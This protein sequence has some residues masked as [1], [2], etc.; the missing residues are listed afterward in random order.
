MDFYSVE[1]HDNTMHTTI[2][3]ILVKEAQHAFY[4]V[5]G[6]KFYS[7]GHANKVVD[8]LVHVIGPN[9]VLNMSRIQWQRRERRSISR[10]ACASKWTSY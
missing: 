4:R 2:I 1:I 7:R 9:N 3:D 5:L 8:C 6:A 10:Y